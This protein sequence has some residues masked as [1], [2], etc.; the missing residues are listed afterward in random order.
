MKIQYDPESDVLYIELREL[1]E[2]KTIRNLDGFKHDMLTGFTY[3]I[4]VKL[5]DVRGNLHEYSDPDYE[6]YMT[7]AFQLHEASKVLGFN[8]GAFNF[9]VKPPVKKSTD[10]NSPVP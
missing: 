2:G 3:E 9:E 6:G 8:P 7:A 10:W 4:L 5:R 1:P